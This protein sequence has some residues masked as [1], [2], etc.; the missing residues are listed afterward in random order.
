MLTQIIIFG[1]MGKIKFRKGG[2]PLAR[3]LVLNVLNHLYTCRNCSCLF[4]L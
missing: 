2:S 4:K 3:G 1:D